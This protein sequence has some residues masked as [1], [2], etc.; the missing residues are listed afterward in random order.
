MADA[1]VRNSVPVPFD[2]TTVPCPN[3]AAASALKHSVT[4]N[5]FICV[6]L[7]IV[8]VSARVCAL[9]LHA[10]GMSS[11]SIVKYSYIAHMAFCKA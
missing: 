7:L 6:F 9:W 1:F 2:V 5:F 3:A 4:A 8:V 10:E 11:S